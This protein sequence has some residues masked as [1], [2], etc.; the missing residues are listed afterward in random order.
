[1]VARAATIALWAVGSAYLVKP[2]LDRAIVDY[3]AIVSTP[4]IW[5]VVISLPILAAYARRERQWTAAIL[6]WLAAVVGSA[7]TMQGTL[8]R[9]AATRDIAVAQAEAVAKQRTTIERDLTA[10]K[11]MLAAARAKCA[12]GR[13]CLPATKAT[14]AVYEGAVAGHEH[15]LSKLVAAAPAAG[16]ARIAALLSFATGATAASSAA[17]VAMIV[18]ALL[19]LTLELSAFAVAMLGWHPPRQVTATA[20]KSSELISTVSKPGQ[21]CAEVRKHPVIAALERAGRPVSNGELAHLM[22]VCA[23]E[24][25]KRRREVADSI[26]EVRVGRHI[27]VSLP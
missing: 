24:A 16:E 13:E 25:T 4:I 26:R 18:P 11:S 23:G 17:I 15:R 20:G 5:A 3:V 19:G 14:I 27:M 10:A 8:G 2:E 22:A 12:A 7:H 1:M 21:L 6:I 9:Q